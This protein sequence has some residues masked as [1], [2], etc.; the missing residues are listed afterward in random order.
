MQITLPADGSV[1][2]KGKAETVSLKDTVTINSYVLPGQGEYDVAGVQCEGFNLSAGL[3]YF[4]RLEDL[5]LTY[6]SQIDSGVSKLDDASN[7]NILIVDVRSDDTA[8]SLKGI[9]KNVEPSFVILCGAG[10]TPEFRTA[11]NLPTQEIGTFKI[12]RAGLPLEGTTI[13]HS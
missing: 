7:C 13:L 1:L 5:Q 4:I 12:S 3:V 8:D 10:A 9:I 6:L 2:I 11:L